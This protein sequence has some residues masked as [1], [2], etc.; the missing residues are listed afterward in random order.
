MDTYGSTRWYVNK[1]SSGDVWYVNADPPYNSV[2]T[3]PRS[4]KI[5]GP[6]SQRSAE[7]PPQGD[8]GERTRWYTD[9]DSTG[10]E[11]YV[12]ADPPYNSV[13]TIPP[14][15]II[16]GPYSQRSSE[17]LS[18]EYSRVSG[19]R[20]D[21]RAP[22]VAPAA[23]APPPQARQPGPAFPSAPPPFPGAQAR[24]P[25]PA[26]PSAPPPFP[27]AQA[28]P[29]APAGLTLLQRVQNFFVGLEN[30]S[31]ALQAIRTIQPYIREINQAITSGIL[32]IS[33]LKLNAKKALMKYHPDKG[34]DP[35][36]INELTPI[37]GESTG[38]K[39][40]GS[41]KHNLQQQKYKLAY[42]RALNNRSR[43]QMY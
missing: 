24:Q 29:R 43:K 36:I 13:W 8:S 2:W 40:Y 26:F 21:P 20:T 33:H 16:L 37:L 14:S 31:T 19:E 3:I 23:A 6:Y 25:G 42:N 35:N 7:R 39:L 28:P 22:P 9:K 12:N 38:M 11:W 27:G 41:S 34:G 18:Q 17:R 1:D 5:L 30:E 15:G 32:D 4:G 10:D